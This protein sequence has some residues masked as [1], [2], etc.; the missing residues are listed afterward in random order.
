MCVSKCLILI[1]SDLGKSGKYFDSLS[2]KLNLFSFSKFKIVAAVNGFVIEPIRNL[3]ESV[4]G[5]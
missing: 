3:V 4:L 1:K 5:I 2:S